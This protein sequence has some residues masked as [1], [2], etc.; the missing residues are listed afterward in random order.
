MR[1]GTL[2]RDDAELRFFDSERGTPILFQHGLG[3]DAAQ[4]AEN[5]PDGPGYRRLT[6]ECRAQGRS[7]PGSVRPFSIAM[8][9]ADV[10]AACDQ[11]GIGRLVVGG[12]STGAAIALQLAVHHPERVTGLVLARPA[13]LFE[14][15]PSN[16]RPFIEIAHLLRTEAPMAARDRFAASPTARM[17]AR[18]A[19]DNLVSLLKFFERPDPLLTADLVAD[20]AL[21]GPGVTA[22]EAAAITVPTLV[23]GHGQDHVHPL[24]HAQALARTI[25][26]AHLV[27]ITPKAADKPRH[28]AEF[29]AALDTFLKQIPC[30][31]ARPCP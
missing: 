5:F 12:I 27:T 20:I 23:L 21:D 4:V 25:P 11:C 26:G 16:M 8:F 29:R 3:G 31:E 2:R 18:E 19:P 22:A 28:V 15:A 7:Q 24:A 6:V 1:L 17:L 10:M 9:A 30:A 14:A 13:W